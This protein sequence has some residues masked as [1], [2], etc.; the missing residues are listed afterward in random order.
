MQSVVSDQGVGIISEGSRDKSQ[1][2]LIGWC[3]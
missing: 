2:R 3:G 1:G